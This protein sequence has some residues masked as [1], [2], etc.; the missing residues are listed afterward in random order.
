MARNTSGKRKKTIQ[1]AAELRRDRDRYKRQSVV[2]A[3]IAFFAWL[4]PFILLMTRVVE[5]TDLLIAIIIPAVVMVVAGVLMS[6][7]VK[8]YQRAKNRFDAFCQK[9][10]AI[11]AQ[12]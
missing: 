5:G 12:K 1:S 8:A 3:I 9:N 11:L 2:L 10:A 7:R 4:T 6:R